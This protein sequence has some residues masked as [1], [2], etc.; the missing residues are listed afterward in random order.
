MAQ[1]LLRRS[2]LRLNMLRKVLQFLKVTP[3]EQLPLL[4]DLHLAMPFVKVHTRLLCIR[5]CQ[6]PFGSTL[7]S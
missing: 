5:C 1:A 7:N 3:Q 4:F 2:E 6:V